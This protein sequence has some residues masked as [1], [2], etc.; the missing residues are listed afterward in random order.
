MKKENEKKVDVI[1][2]KKR[3]EFIIQYLGLMVFLGGIFAGAFLIALS[4]ESLKIENIVMYFIMCAGII[5]ASY[6]FRYIAVILGGMQTLFYTAYKIY[7]SIVN[8]FEIEL[9]SYLWLILPLLSIGAMLLF[10]QTTY[11]TEM[12]AEM[13][14]EQIKD[15]VVI[16]TVTGL[17]NLKSMYM[18][19]ERQMAYSARNEFP[20]SLMIVQLRYEQEL[21]SILNGSQ[22]AELKR[23]MAEKVED[24]IRLEDRIY[25]IDENGSL[26]IICTCGKDGTEIM[27]R[28]IRES[29][30]EKESFAGILDKAIRVDI[31]TGS[32]E[33]D[34]EEIKNAIEFKQKAE[35]ELQYDV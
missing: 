12:M 1:L 24:S 9:H 14:E 21:R 10:M 7:Q 4:E 11:K 32:L 5:L 22:F 26:G 35:N 29:L 28:R 6:R 3:I 19:L 20:L 18:D 30:N 17:Y 15:M 23:K 16:E 34:K 33:Y 25:A 8:G 13:L 27:K 31:R 2:R